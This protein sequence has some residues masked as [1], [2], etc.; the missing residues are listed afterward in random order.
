MQNEKLLKNYR[1]QISSLDKEIIYL[2]SRRFIIVNEIWN[3]KKQENIPVLQKDI[4]EKLLSENIE[5]AQELGLEIKLIE[6]I[7]NRIHEESLRIE[8]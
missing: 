4:W 7:W 6:D 5:K 3:I 2:L 8:E 1:E